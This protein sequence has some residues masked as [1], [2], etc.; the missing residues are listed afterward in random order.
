MRAT[1]LALLRAGPLAVRLACLRVRVH[2]AG[3]EMSVRQDRHANIV[4]LTGIGAHAVVVSP[5]LACVVGHRGWGLGADRH[6]LAAGVTWTA[7][8]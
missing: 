7:A 6:R 1:S 5:R 2:D 4:Q 3:C 8:R